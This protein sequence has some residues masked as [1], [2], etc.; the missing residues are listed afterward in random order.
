VEED[1]SVAA[2]IPFHNSLASAPEAARAAFPAV[3]PVPP[4]AQQ[5]RRRGIRWVA[6]SF[7]FCPCHLPI[8]LTVLASLLGGT[9]LGA[10][11]HHYPLVAAGIITAVWAAGTWRGLRLVRAVRACT[12]CVA[13]S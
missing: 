10:A 2:P 9:T 3:C 8:T 12:T 6:G 11:L 4:V 5:T 1:V 13:A 7:L